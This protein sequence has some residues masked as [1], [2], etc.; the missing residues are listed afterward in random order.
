MGRTEASRVAAESSVDLVPVKRTVIKKYA[1]K[2]NSITV[3]PESAVPA[4]RMLAKNY[5]TVITVVVGMVI[6]AGAAV[7]I[8]VAVIKFAAI[9]GAPFIHNMSSFH[10][11]FSKERLFFYFEMFIP[12]LRLILLTFNL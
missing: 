3:P 2:V 7:E 6:L 11:L 1:I 8:A 4:G 9:N 5:A 10:H 12:V